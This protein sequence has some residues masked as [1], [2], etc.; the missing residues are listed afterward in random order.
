MKFRNNM[1]FINARIDLLRLNWKS[2]LGNGAGAIIQHVFL[3]TPPNYDPSNRG[4]ILA[5][6]GRLHQQGNDSS[7]VSLTDDFTQNEM[8]SLMVAIQNGAL[9]FV[10]ELQILSPMSGA[11]RE[12]LILALNL[13]AM[14]NLHRLQVHGLK[15]INTYGQ[16]GYKAM[17]EALY[18][19][20]RHVVFTGKS[21]YDFDGVLGPVL[22]PKSNVSSLI[23]MDT[24]PYNRSSNVDRFI[25]MLCDTPNTNNLTWLSLRAT[26]LRDVDLA[27][28]A[29]RGPLP[30]LSK[31]KFLDVTDNRQITSR[32]ESDLRIILHQTPS[33]ENIHVGSGGLYKFMTRAKLARAASVRKRSRNNPYA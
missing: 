18:N 29:V 21:A 17:F 13:G 22:Q 24:N 27:V 14:P 25:T 2:I 6:G 5:H 7:S 16:V 26:R 10:Q 4:I 8:L 20:V 3:D 30:S 9:S 33:L 11:V 31:L 1:E 12:A 32:G 19:R 28:L 15:K 23:I